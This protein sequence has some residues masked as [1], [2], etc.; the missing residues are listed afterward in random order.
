MDTLLAMYIKG[1]TFPV[2]PLFGDRESGIDGISH[3]DLIVNLLTISFQKLLS[4]LHAIFTCP[5]LVQR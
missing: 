3:T 2:D 5:S 1:G 4:T